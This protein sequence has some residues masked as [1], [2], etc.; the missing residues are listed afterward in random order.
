MEDRYTHWLAS[1]SVSGDF[2]SVGCQQVTGYCLINFGK[3]WVKL[4]WVSFLQDSSGGF[5]MLI[6]TETLQE[7]LITGREPFSP[8]IILQSH[9]GNSYSTPGSTG[10]GLSPQH[11]TS[12]RRRNEWGSHHR[13]LWDVPLF[14]EKRRALPVPGSPG[15]RGPPQ[16]QAH[17]TPSSPSA[18]SLAPQRPCY[19]P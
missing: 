16:N 14:S 4:I 11:C 6:N 10:V 12:A 1:Y 17:T 19:L 9:S 18:A 15:V 13:Q 2:S 3:H 7:E 5:N 8:E